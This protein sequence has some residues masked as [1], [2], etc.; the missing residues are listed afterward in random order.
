KGGVPGLRRHKPSGRAVVRLNGDDHYLG[1]WPDGLKEAPPEARAAYDVLIARWL[2]GRREPLPPA[3]GEER[4][5]LGQA[6]SP[7]GVPI[8]AELAVRYAGHARTYYSHPDGS[9]TSEYH[10]IVYSLRPLVHLF[11]RAAA[12]DV[13]PLKLKAVRELMIVGYH[14]PKYGDQPA[15]SRGVINA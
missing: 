10:E 7:A 5:L 1:P 3:E 11:C 12:A 2:A 9:P 6:G 4:R 13:G 15:L 8:V 14:H